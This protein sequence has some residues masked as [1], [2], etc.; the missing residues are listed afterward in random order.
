MI[1]RADEAIPARSG[2]QQQ[3]NIPDTNHAPNNK[4]NNISV[5]RNNNSIII[6]GGKKLE[7]AAKNNEV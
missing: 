3:V 2:Q 4:T 7:S 6:N 1:Y 5:V